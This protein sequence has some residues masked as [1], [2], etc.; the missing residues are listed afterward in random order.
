[1]CPPRAL[2]RSAARAKGEEMNEPL[3]SKEFGFSGRTIILIVLAMIAARRRGNEDCPLA[4]IYA[5]GG[6]S[7]HADV[8]SERHETGPTDCKESWLKDDLTCL[9]SN[10]IQLATVGSRLSVRT[11]TSEEIAV[12]KEPDWV[13]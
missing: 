2:R 7:S 13:F 5:G 10:G 3:R 12:S 11:A 1:M 8:R 6:R 4:G 9:R